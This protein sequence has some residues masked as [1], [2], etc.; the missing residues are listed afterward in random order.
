MT[1]SMRNLFLPFILA[2]TIAA[3]C[4]CSE[5]GRSGSGIPGPNQ[6][7]SE[8]QVERNTI[9]KDVLGGALT[10]SIDPVAFSFD[11]VAVRAMTVNVEFSTTISTIN[12]YYT[13][14][15][16]DGADSLTINASGNVEEIETS[17]TGSSILKFVPLNL[18]IHFENFFFTNSCGVQAVLTGDMECRVKG[19]FIRETENFKGTAMCTSGT[20]IAPSDIIYFFGDIEHKIH[21]T[22]N[23]TAD[24]NAF[25]LDSYNFSG[26]FFLDNRI[27]AIGTIDEVF[28]CNVE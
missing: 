18:L 4:A 21:L 16:S 2:L 10:T 24:G 13:F 27:V 28:T 23:V 9:V 14:K 8:A 22:V 11:D 12:E 19:D 6:L 25:N 3:L 15:G 17:E 20:F 26:S 5:S 7:I 1:I